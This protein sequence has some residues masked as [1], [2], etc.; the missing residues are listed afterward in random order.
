MQ[1]QKL[2]N[3]TKGIANHEEIF[4]QGDDSDTPHQVHDYMIT[5]R[6]QT[7]DRQ[8]RSGYREPESVVVED[9]HK[10]RPRAGVSSFL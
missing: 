3:T 5:S 4:S 10:K 2:Y 8:S 9:F 6:A 7:S 1:T